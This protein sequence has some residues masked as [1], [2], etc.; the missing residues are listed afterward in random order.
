M[1]N[2][3]CTICDGC[4][5]QMNMMRAKRA[6]EVIDDFDLLLCGS[7]RDEAKARDEADRSEA[8]IS[9]LVTECARYEAALI[10]IR[11]FDIEHNGSLS[12]ASVIADAALTPP[13]PLD[14][15]PLTADEIDTV[16]DAVTDAML[17]MSQVPAE[18]K[19]AARKLEAALIA[20]EEES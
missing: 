7:C 5:T 3:W 10:K 4:G 6:M 20:L 2:E 17:G 8:V 13:E 14:L 19:S 12:V 16:L 15:E 1:S 11:D 9:E 18:A